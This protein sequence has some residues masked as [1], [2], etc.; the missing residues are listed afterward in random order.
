[1]A[2]LPLSLLSVSASACLMASPGL[3]EA[4]QVVLII[5]ACFHLLSCG[6]FMMGLGVLTGMRHLLLGFEVH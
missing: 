6:Q 5:A 1:M 2:A 3:S 4:Q